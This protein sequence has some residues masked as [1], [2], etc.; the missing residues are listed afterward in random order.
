MALRMEDN[1]S[2]DS[3]FYY[4]YD[5]GRSWEGPFRLPRF[6]LH[7][8]IARTEYLIDGPRTC[9]IFLT[10]AKQTLREGTSV[11]AR[12]T[13]GGLTWEYLGAILNEPEGYAIM[14][15]AVRLDDTGLLAVI[16]ERAPKQ[17][18][19]WLSVFRSNDNGRT[20]KQLPRLADTAIGNPAAL[21]K[22]ADGR[23]VA[24]YGYRAEPYSILAKISRDN[25]E[26]WSEEII[27]RDDGGDRDIGYP[28]AKLRADGKI[29]ATYY[30]NDR[31]GRP[32]RYIAA[33]IWDPDA[34]EVR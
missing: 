24:V 9:T 17:G 30:F 6:G 28:R 19:S 26:T 5:R 8:A 1:H 31:E 13:D 34:V 15:A 20:W 10:A 33:T 21:V 18:P 22:L 3:R 23:I 16:R 27:L 29:V 25:G 2:G 7:G 12:T 11:S 4:S 32:E 14:P